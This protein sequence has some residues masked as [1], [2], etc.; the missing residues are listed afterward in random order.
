MLEGHNS[1]VYLVG[2]G[3]AS[4]SAAVFL[5]KDAEVPG[6]NITIFENSRVFGGSLDADENNKDAYVM[7]G[8]RILAKKTFEC[9]LDMLDHIPSI[10]DTKKSVRQEMMEFN[11]QV[12]TY[13]KARLI[14][15]GRV[16]DAHSLGLSWR[17]RYDLFK[18]ITKDES[19]IQ[20]K[21]INEHFSNHFF[22]TN[23]WLEFRT[24]FAFQPW[25]SLVEFKRYLLR[26]FHALSYYNTLECIIT[27]P[28]TQHDSFILPITKWLE[29]KGVK[30]W[31]ECRVFDLKIESENRPKAIK[32]ILYNH[33]GQQKSIT[34]E[35]HD[36]IIITLGSMTANT[37]VGSNTKAPDINIHKSSPSWSFW[38][39]L[40]RGN[41]NFGNPRA[42]D[43][44]INRSSW[45]SFTIT[46]NNS[47]FF[48]LMEK[49]TGNKAGEG[50]GST[51]KGSNWL[52]SIAIPHQ[53]HFLGQPKDKQICWGYSLAPDHKGNFVKKRM[54][55]CSG[56]EILTELI[57]HL[58]FDKHK[59]KILDSAIC[60]PC[61]MPYITSQFSLRSKH[62]RPYI[63]PSNIKNLGLIGQFVEIP[64][65]VSFT[66]EYSIR[67][68]QIAVY[69]L[70]NVN[71]KIPS[72]YK[73]H[74]N[75][76]NIYKAIKTSLR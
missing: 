33:K 34:L 19:D 45:E 32:N 30:F 67:S 55:D 65:D 59:D 54:L 61:I 40:A 70:F 29:E 51:L 27:A 13:A 17:D 41:T 21:R 23:F 49:L 52:M 50:G 15:C 57:R 72:I 37:A 68:A 25:H 76:K 26:S 9:T 28:L 60:L 11:E 62:D 22:K 20:S 73:G 38:E 53:P 43:S 3:I 58:G 16:V 7:R 75:L 69:S 46:F 64:D 5:I 48:D 66:I 39:K 44:H 1:K 4:L 31:D 74:H 6:S 71:K 63:I 42:F 24:V 2:G 10:T 47:L 18:V 56:Q 12:K 8:H 36:H 35:S 14:D